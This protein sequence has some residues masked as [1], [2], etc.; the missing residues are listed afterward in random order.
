[1]PTGTE[2]LNIVILGASFAGCAAAHHFLSRV[3]PT[4]GATADAPKYRVVLI[5]P[6][7]HI[8]WNIGAPRILVSEDLIPYEDA[9][10]AIEPGFERYGKDKFAFIQAAAKS[11]DTETQLITLAFTGKT[12]K[13]TATASRRAT[14]IAGKRSSQGPQSPK[15]QHYHQRSA[16]SG[17]SGSAGFSPIIPYH[18]LI[19]A[20]GSSTYSPLLTLQGPHE[21]TRAALD[22]VH[23]RIP[24]ATNIVVAG[25]GP[26]GV[27]TAGQLATFYR[28]KLAFASSKLSRRNRTA[29]RRERQI[30][31]IS[32]S[33]ALLPGVNSALGHKAEKQLR[34]LGIKILHNTRIVSGF[35]NDGSDPNHPPKGSNVRTT[36][37]LSD[38]TTL[39]D[40]DLYIPCT[41]VHPNTA[42]LPPAFLSAS[43]YANTDTTPLTLRLVPRAP[44]S[45]DDPDAPTSPSRLPRAERIYAVG[46]C[47]SYSANYVLDVY[48][49]IPVL[50]HNLTNDL[51]AWEL[52]E[53]QPYGGNEDELEAIASSDAVFQGRRVK[54]AEKKVNEGRKERT[55][56][57]KKLKKRVARMTLMSSFLDKPT[58][59]AEAVKETGKTKR[60]SFFDGDNISLS[61]AVKLANSDYEGDTHDGPPTLA[62]PVV[63]KSRWSGLSGKGKENASQGDVRPLPT[64]PRR[65]GMAD[66]CEFDPDATRAAKAATPSTTPATAPPTAPANPDG[67]SVPPST[68][69]TRGSAN[70]HLPDEHN[71]DDE[72]GGKEQRVL[73][74]TQLVP[75][76]R[77]GG[78]GVVFGFRLPSLMVW[79]LKGRDYRVGKGKAVVWNGNN[80]Y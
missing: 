24:S 58:E 80:P 68:A 42:Y 27:E 38:G 56:G 69:T 43:G 55:Q 49:A 13:E 29:L 45:S 11:L 71:A 63:D 67:F 35:T 2:P 3:L 46:D 53:A 48:D 6:S 22:A 41:G 54:I 78:V 25:G 26:T 62:S 14:M 1:M 47:A 72:A 28:S 57:P 23:R 20:T 77:F 70:D 59:E 36:L 33:D 65:G 50:M 66:T 10:V 61:E 7:T 76:T 73:V 15:S 44:D 75:I 16:S 30:T 4:L 18:A 21:K 74:D 60:V 52:R 79:L 8:Y 5:S 32:G 40:V 37:V 64:G 39:E 17:S 12:G 9:F 34:G 31:L 19:L 51:L